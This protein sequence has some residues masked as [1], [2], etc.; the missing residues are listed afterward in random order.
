MG[1]GEVQVTVVNF[2]VT[3]RWCL[4][5][6]YLENCLPVA[7]PLAVRCGPPFW[8]WDVSWGIW[9]PVDAEIKIKK[10][11][12]LGHGMGGSAQYGGCLQLECAEPGCHEIFDLILDESCLV[13]HFWKPP[14]DGGTPGICWFINPMNTH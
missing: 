11:P 3:P 4:S 12:S 10:H 1:I 13:L 5:K 8:S 6:W 2:G 9:F 14:L 7:F